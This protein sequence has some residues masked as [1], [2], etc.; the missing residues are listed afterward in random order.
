MN[1]HGVLWLKTTLN[2]VIARVATSL[3][4]C[5]MCCKSII[6]CMIKVQNVTFLV[7]DYYLISTPLEDLGTCN[8][9]T[10]QN[11]EQ[12]DRKICLM[13]CTVLL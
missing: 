12:L 10:E 8:L 4:R 6:G 11:E 7:Y 2:T 9:R 13:I 5:N 1:M 3:L